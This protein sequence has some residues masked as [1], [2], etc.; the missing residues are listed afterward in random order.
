MIYRWTDFRAAIHDDECVRPQIHLAVALAAALCVLALASIFQIVW[1]VWLL[2]IVCGLLVAVLYFL[3]VYVNLAKWNARPERDM[4]LI[5]VGTAAALLVNSVVRD[6]G[7]QLNLL[8]WGCISLSLM[9]LFAY[10]A[11][12]LFRLVSNG[13]VYGVFPV[14]EFTDKATLCATRDNI[15]DP[16]EFHISHLS[17]GLLWDPVFPVSDDDHAIITA[18]GG[19]PWLPGELQWPR[20]DQGVPLHFFAQIDLE[21]LPVLQAVDPH[22]G[23]LPTHPVTGVLFIFLLAGVDND[24]IFDS[25]EQAQ[26]KVLYSRT[27]GKPTTHRDLP[28]DLP[29]LNPYVQWHPFLWDYSVAKFGYAGARPNRTL[30]RVPLKAKSCLTNHDFPEL[31]AIGAGSPV[32]E[33]KR[34]WLITLRRAEI[35]R[36][37]DPLDVEPRQIPLGFPSLRW[38]WLLR[39]QR[40][41]DFSTSSR[42]TDV[43]QNYPWHWLQI[44]RT[45]L[46]VV[47]HCIQL[48]ER[49]GTSS[50]ALGSLMHHREQ[51]YEWI[52]VATGYPEF[53]EVD[54]SHRLEFQQWLQQ[55]VDIQSETPCEVIRR[56]RDLQPHSDETD[57]GILISHCVDVRTFARG[58]LNDGFFMAWP[59]CAASGKLSMIPAEF[60]QAMK[61]GHVSGSDGPVLIH[62]TFGELGETYQDDPSQRGFVPLLQ[63][64][65]AKAGNLCL[66]S[67]VGKVSF[68][69]DPAAMARSDFSDVTACFHM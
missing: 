32:S 5:V 27:A 3:H 29:P 28:S 4:Y 20:D 22:I 53:S 62:Q 2:G 8:A 36:E 63:I 37:Q 47:A 68:W 64:A 7:T 38:P 9:G 54:A 31:A 56:F 10:L 51:A 43:P 11:I 69:I 23:S 26:C 42:V 6:T 67:S 13:F 1:I 40:S 34:K 18:I 15:D 48:D 17:Q 46:A 19:Q 59:Y 12:Q 30:P 39:F 33:I 21:S 60:I 61:P 52:K 57:Q 55:M 50:T 49:S 44:E 16:Y 25:H 45:A 65:S 14:R 24:E 58:V 66:G 41:D 35:S